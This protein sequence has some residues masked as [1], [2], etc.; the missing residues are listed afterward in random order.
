MPR[1]KAEK[2]YG[3]CSGSGQMITEGLEFSIVKGLFYLRGYEPQ[4]PA[5]PP[6]RKP[7]KP[8]NDKATTPETPLELLSANGLT[9]RLIIEQELT[10]TQIVKKVQDFYPEREETRIRRDIVDNRK[11]LNSGKYYTSWTRNF[12]VTKKLIEISTP[13]TPKRKLLKRVRSK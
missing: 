2:S 10:D 5:R 7:R 8:R 9:I 1:I 3:I 11:K 6:K 13:A 12:H 4:A